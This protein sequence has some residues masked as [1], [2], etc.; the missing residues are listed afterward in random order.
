MVPDSDCL[1]GILEWVGLGLL[2]DSIIEP[3]RILIEPYSI[4]RVNPIV[5]PIVLVAE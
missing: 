3:C 4:L 1:K 2:S 5:E